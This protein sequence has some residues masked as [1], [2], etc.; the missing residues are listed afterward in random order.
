VYL[1]TYMLANAF[2]LLLL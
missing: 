2:R 1:F